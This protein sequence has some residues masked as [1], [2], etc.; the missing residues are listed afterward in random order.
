MAEATRPS[1]KN[2]FSFLVKFN[3]CLE[4]FTDLFNRQIRFWHVEQDKDMEEVLPNVPLYIHASLF[5]QVVQDGTAVILDFLAAA[6]DEER[7]EAREVAI[8]W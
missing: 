1:S 5:A 3:S 8:D 4:K 2:L 6:I 7:R